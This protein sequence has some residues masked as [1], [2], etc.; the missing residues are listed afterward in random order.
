MNNNTNEKVIGISFYKMKFKNPKINL[1]YLKSLLK[2]SI[3]IETKAKAKFDK[4]EKK[5][6]LIEIKFIIQN[7]L[8][9]AEI[10]QLELAIADEDNEF[11]WIGNKKNIFYEKD[12][13][14]KF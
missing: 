4:G 13:V 9:T 11:T 8:E 10:S 14:K 6:V 5:F 2:N 12:N 3:E 7:I 1:S